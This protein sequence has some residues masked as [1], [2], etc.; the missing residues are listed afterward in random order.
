MH[1]HITIPPAPH[2]DLH[3]IV[4]LAPGN[5]KR[6]VQGGSLDEGELYFDAISVGGR[7]PGT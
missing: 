1:P 3:R 5:S 6:Y 4:V 2:S 7:M